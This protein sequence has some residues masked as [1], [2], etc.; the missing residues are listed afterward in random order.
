MLWLWYAQ[1]LTATC[2][3]AHDDI[4]I[5]TPAPV[6]LGEVVDDLVEPASDKV[7]ELHF[8]HGLLARDGQAQA[9]A[10]D[11]RLA[12]WRV[13]N[14]LLTEGVDKPIRHLEHAS[15]RADVLPH[16]YQ[17]GVLLHACSQALGDGVDEAKLSFATVWR[18]MQALGRAGRK[19]I[20]QFFKGVGHNGWLRG[21]SFQA[22]LNLGLEGAPKVSFFGF[23][24]TPVDIKCAFKRATGSTFVQV[25]M[26]PSG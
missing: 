15:I 6:N 3:H 1:R 14:A 11:G 23:V 4:R 24:S 5:L 16:K 2:W 17:I 7:T 8:H 22:F 25:S 13:S 10:H 21:G 26:S 18:D 12:Q 20:V 19:S 9:R